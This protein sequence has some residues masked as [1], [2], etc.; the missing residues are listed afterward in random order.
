MSIER[1]AYL[2]VEFSG[3]TYP[4]RFQRPLPDRRAKDAITLSSQVSASAA[5]KHGVI[6]DD[7]N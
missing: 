6:S 5:A 1:A 2:T 4:L 3:H 7:V